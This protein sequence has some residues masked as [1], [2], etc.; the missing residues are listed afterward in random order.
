MKDAP[1]LFNVI[2]KAKISQR[3]RF[4]LLALLLA[5]YVINSIS[6]LILAKQLPNLLEWLLNELTKY[7]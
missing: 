4:F 2:N 5:P 6:G 3:D 7:L 1:K